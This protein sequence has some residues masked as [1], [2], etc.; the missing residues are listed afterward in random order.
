VETLTPSDMLIPTS[1]DLH[2]GIASRQARLY[3]GCMMRGNSHQGTGV[4]ESC[5]QTIPLCN[6]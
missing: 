4:D 6:Y 3:I 1:Q 5:N 2:A